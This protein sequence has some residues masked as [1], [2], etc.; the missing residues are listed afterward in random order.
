[1]S[2]LALDKN[3]PLDEV[4][5]AMDVVD[6]LRHRA[7]IVERELDKDGQ[8]TNLVERLK[9]I[10]AAQGIDVPDH[11][12]SQGVNALREDRFTYVPTPPSVQRR[13]AEFYIRRDKWG[14]PALLGCALLVGAFMAWQS[15]IV[16]PEARETEQIQLEL[17]ETLPS[18]VT[19][20]AERI[21]AISLD[22][23]ATH[24]TYALTENARTAIADG[25]INAARS[26]AQELSDIA[27]QLQ[28]SYTLRVIARPG[29]LSGVWRI[30]D[31]NRSSRNYYVIV[32]PVSDNGTILSMP[33]TNEE[34]NRYQRVKKMGIRVSRTVFEQVQADKLD[35]G[36]I[37]SNIIGSKPRGY[38]QPNFNVPVLGGIITEW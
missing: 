1:M 29:E 16:W 34:S 3:A 28:Q 20:L 26:H 9:T 10:Y 33:V 31:N 15:L 18:S 4:M 5:L 13:L 37:Q 35:D 21:A 14:R 27:T 19:K 8:D 6:T 2:N 36:I 17:N 22:E 7:R 24:R 11:I 25:D 38:L 32:E 12:L 23:R 30:P